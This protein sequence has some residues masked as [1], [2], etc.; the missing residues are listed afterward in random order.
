MFHGI[1]KKLNS[2]ISTEL[3][4]NH[5]EIRDKFRRNSAGHP[6][7]KS[8]KLTGRTLHFFQKYMFYFK[9]VNVKTLI[10]IKYNL[11]FANPDT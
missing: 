8:D 3:C 6:S 5:T 9:N 1:P 4:R 10:N 7:S 2:F 11:N